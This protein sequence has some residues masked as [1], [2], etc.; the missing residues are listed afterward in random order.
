MNYAYFLVL[1][2]PLALLPYLIYKCYPLAEPPA[3][4]IPDNRTAVTNR[5]GRV[6]LK[7]ADIMTRRDMMVLVFDAI[8]FALYAVKKFK[9]PVGQQVMDIISF[10]TPLM[11]M[12]CL[13]WHMSYK[14]SQ[15]L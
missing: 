14:V 7:F 6:L 10:T 1:I 9:S 12:A 2:S 11:Q 5:V 15:F 8:N 3:T 4:P 13:S